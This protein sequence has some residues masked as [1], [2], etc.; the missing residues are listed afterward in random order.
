[1]K[2]SIIFT[3]IPCALLFCVANAFKPAVIDD[4]GYIWYVR[5][6]AQTP[7]QPFGPPPDGF[8]LN[9]YQYG[10]PAF[11]LLTPMVLPYWLAVG[12]SLFGENLFLFKLWLF[13]FCLLFTT[14]LFSLFRRFAPGMEKP[15]LALT[16]FSPTFLPSLNVMVDVP[17]IALNLTAIAFFCRALDRPK[18][19]WRMIMVAG[20]V[21]GLAAQTKYTG[22]TALAVLFLYGIARRQRLPTI[23]AIVIA[24]GIFVGWEAYLTHVY[25]RSHFLLQLEIRRTKSPIDE[26]ASALQRLGSEI[27]ATL[28]KKASM[29]SPLFGYL[30]GLGMGMIPLFLLGL[31]F[32]I[33]FVHFFT[34]IAI[35]GFLTMTL[36]PERWA[37][38]YRDVA[39]DRNVVSVGTILMGA[40]GVCFALLL[41]ASCAVLAFKR[42]LRI[43][44]S[45]TCWFLIGWLMVEFLA[46][47]VLTPFAAAR[48]AMGIVVVASMM[49]GRILSTNRDPER[50]KWVHRYCALGVAIGFVYAWTDYRDAVAEHNALFESIKLVHEQSGGRPRIWFAGHW[51]FQYYGEREG[52]QT[53]YPDESIIEAGDWI[54]VPDSPPRPYAQK[55]QLRTPFAEKRGVVEIHEGWPLNTNPIYYDGYMPIRRH[56]GFRLRVAIYRANERFRVLPY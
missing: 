4:L 25:G 20:L 32:P 55:F 43:R 27:D 40:T 50:G 52:L 36:L 21:A 19:R 44:R 49:I 13:P 15:L 47:Y 10:Q 9:W 23:A 7:L 1:M 33:R 42:T 30:G 38:F 22:I 8:Y 29:T 31:R 51:G 12:Y 24:T 46:Y 11:T 34:A 6:I 56:D 41:S 39:N 45:A 17:A 2:W 26:S 28:E 53:V 54:I 18:P 16:A 48:R 35:A 3:P 14:S 5:Q 37:T